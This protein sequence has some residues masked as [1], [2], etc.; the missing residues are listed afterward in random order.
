MADLERE[1]FDIEERLVRSGRQSVSERGSCLQIFDVTPEFDLLPASRP[2]RRRRS[3][4]SRSAGGRL[5]GPSRHSLRLNHKRRKVT[6]LTGTSGDSGEED[7]LA[8]VDAEAEFGAVEK[9]SAGAASEEI[10]YE[11]EEHMEEDKA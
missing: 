5:Q 11:M 4:P 7:T 8:A 3:S 6:N 2:L 10:F 1:L 9:R